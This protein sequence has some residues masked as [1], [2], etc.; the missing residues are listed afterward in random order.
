MRKA[1]CLPLGTIVDVEEEREKG[2]GFV[3]CKPGPVGKRFLVL[4]AQNQGA[5]LD[6]G[7]N[8]PVGSCRGHHHDLAGK[9]QQKEPEF[10]S[11]D[12]V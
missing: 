11:V 3:S 10:L 1:Y 5:S 7:A 4:D 2:I 6:R 9:H 12:I 8:Q